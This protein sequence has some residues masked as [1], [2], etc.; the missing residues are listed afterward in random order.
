MLLQSKVA[1]GV[2][3]MMGSTVMMGAPP[4]LANAW[5]QGGAVVAFISFLLWV[6]RLLIGELKRRET[7]E[8]ALQIEVRELMRETINE[9]NKTNRELAQELKTRRKAREEV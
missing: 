2:A 6:I 1:A 8:R 7:K 3:G 5:L 9:S 4:V